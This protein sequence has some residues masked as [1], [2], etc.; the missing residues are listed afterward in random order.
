MDFTSGPTPIIRKLT[1]GAG[2]PIDRVSLEA[3]LLAALAPGEK[4]RYVPLA[5]IPEHVRQAVLAIEDQR[6]YDHPGV[7][8]IRAVGAL[9]SNLR[10]NKKYLEGA[11]RSRSRSSRTRS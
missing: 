5:S 3:P 2:K 7:D 6:F 8:P 9:M 1:D 11:A 10:G 4:R